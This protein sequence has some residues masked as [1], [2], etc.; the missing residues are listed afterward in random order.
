MIELEELGL[1]KMDFLGLRTLTVI[2]DAL[3]LIE[4]NH[5]IKIDF[6]LV[7]L[8]DP[9]IL[10]MFAR[11]ETLGVFQFESQGMRN[12]LRELKPDAFEDLVLSQ[13]LCLDRDQ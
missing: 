1:L 3:K 11:A 13:M 7:E 4:E 12:F 9:K 6:S 5:G 2:R 10:E 8:N